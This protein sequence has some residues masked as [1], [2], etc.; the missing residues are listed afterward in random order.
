MTGL[1]EFFA[2][3]HWNDYLDIFILFLL[4]YRLVLLIRGTRSA[5]ILIGLGLLLILYFLSQWLELFTLNWIFSRFGDAFLIALIIIFQDDIR[6][7]LAHVGR[8][9]FFAS[10]NRVEQTQIIH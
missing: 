8:N 2:S 5:Q 9:P 10:V 6:R 1:L 7:A 4:T 3:L